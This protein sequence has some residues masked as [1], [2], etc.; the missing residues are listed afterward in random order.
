MDVAGPSLKV[1]STMSVGYGSLVS[2]QDTLLLSTEYFFKDHVELDALRLRKIPLGYTPDVLT[3]AGALLLPK[4]LFSSFLLLSCYIV[5]TARIAV[6]DITVMLALMAGRN[7][8]EAFPIVLDGQVRF[9]MEL[10][11]SKW[12]I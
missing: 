7:V 1:V 4:H 12:L 10:L 9:L 6:A 8:R 5:V 11:N 2:L 3:E